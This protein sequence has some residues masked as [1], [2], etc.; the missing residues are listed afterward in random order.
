MKFIKDNFWQMLIAGAILLW[1]GWVSLGV[2][3]SVPKEKLDKTTDRFTRLVELMV[4][5][6]NEKL[7]KTTDQFTRLVELMVTANKEMATKQDLREIREDMREIREDMRAG[8][9]RIDRRLEAFEKRLD[10]KSR[11]NSTQ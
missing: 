5:A 2:H 1:I 8:F 11:S 10:G 3:H 7:D 6:N 9:E 4:T